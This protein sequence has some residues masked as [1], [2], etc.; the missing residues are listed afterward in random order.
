MQL[1]KAHGNGTKNSHAGMKTERRRFCA[2]D[3]EMPIWREAAT[4]AAPTEQKRPPDEP[5]GVLLSKTN[6]MAPLLLS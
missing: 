1:S 5:A 4:Q 2:Q 6:F 3:P